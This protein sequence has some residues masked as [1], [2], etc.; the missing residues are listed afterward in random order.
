MAFSDFF[1]RKKNDT[2]EAAQAERET[3]AAAAEEQTDGAAETVSETVEHQPETAAEPATEA[4]AATERPSE[5]R[6]EPEPTPSFFA[7]TFYFQTAF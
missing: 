5:N 2:A 6:H 3:E 4:E 7:F 1:R